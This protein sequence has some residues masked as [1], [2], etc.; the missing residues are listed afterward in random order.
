MSILLSSS[1]AL[2][3]LLP[4][5]SED[6]RLLGDVQGTQTGLNAQYVKEVSLDMCNWADRPIASVCTEQN[7]TDAPTSWNK[8]NALACQSP[9][10]NPPSTSWFDYSPSE[11]CRIDGYT[12][13]SSQKWRWDDGRMVSGW[14]GPEIHC[15]TDTAQLGTQLF[16]K[17]LTAFTPGH[18]FVQIPA[19]FIHQTAKTVRVQAKMTVV[20][21]RP[22][23]PGGLP[24]KPM[25]ALLV[26]QQNLGNGLW[27]DLAIQ[28]I[29]AKDD[30]GYIGPY[31]LYEAQATVAPF[32]EVRLQVR[33]GLMPPIIR[34]DERQWY[35]NYRLIVDLV[36]A[37]LILPDCIPDM[38]RPGECL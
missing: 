34:S 32:T 23:T 15:P 31:V 16:T 17:P 11:P 19:L 8:T 36:E 22:Y 26:L 27:S 18:V 21:S 1:S 24:A 29:T 14:G 9:G 2:A 35:E 30:W 12:G 10:A 38:S 5:A 4:Q 7:P 33:A 20:S 28:E 13:C 3:G 25:S 6:M 37:R